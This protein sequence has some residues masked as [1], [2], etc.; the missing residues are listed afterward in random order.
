MKRKLMK[1]VLIVGIAFGVTA[2]GL[3]TN[4]D[5]DATTEQRESDNVKE[6]STLKKEDGKYSNFV[7][8]DEVKDSKK[9]DLVMQIE[10]KYFY[11]GM[12][13]GE[14]RELLGELGYQE[15]KA[16]DENDQEITVLDGAKSME[17]DFIKNKNLAIIVFILNDLRNETV[18]LDDCIV[19]GF[20][21][22]QGE[23]YDRTAFSTGLSEKNVLGK[24]FDEI[25]E[26]MQ[27]NFSDYHVK[28]YE[29][30]NGN[31][32]VQF[33][34]GYDMQFRLPYTTPVFAIYSFTFTP[35]KKECIAFNGKQGVSDSLESGKEIDIELP[36]N[37]SLENT[38][39]DD[40]GDKS[41]YPNVTIEYADENNKP[42]YDE[43]YTVL[44]AIGVPQ[45]EVGTATISGEYYSDGVDAMLYSVDF[46][47]V[48]NHYAYA[49][50]V[51][52][53]GEIVSTYVYTENE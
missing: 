49:T 50:V 32:K 21:V 33:S 3:S 51:A 6:E 19:Y 24:S 35:D 20:K 5:T 17:I 31:I 48:D 41:S 45:S 1:L 15:M 4:L 11:I 18:D 27:K 26:Y 7:I 52:G 47:S 23:D 8:L 44:D 38:E 12:P 14:V 53:E 22:N 16:V 37:E 2:C 36:E 29:K 10:D 34:K 46:Y 25:V 39:D 28:A 30:D 40:L 42:N 9:D 13:F 43:I